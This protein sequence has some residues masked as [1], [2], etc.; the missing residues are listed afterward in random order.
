MEPVTLHG[1]LDQRFGRGRRR[2][3]GDGCFGVGHGERN[4]IA[5]IARHAGLDLSQAQ[6][7]Q[8]CAAAPYMNAML[9]RLRRD[10]HWGEEPANSFR[11][12]GI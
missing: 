6:F 9:G 5:A 4:R 1:G 11:F 3:V 10:R 8:V 12:P 2:R 7:E